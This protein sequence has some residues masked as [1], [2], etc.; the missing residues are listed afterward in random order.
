MKRV[1]ILVV[2][3]GLCMSCAT[4]KPLPESSINTTVLNVLGGPSKVE[5][6]ELSLVPDFVDE[7]LVLIRTTEITS[8]G[9]SSSSHQ[10]VDAP[11]GLY[12]GNG[13]YL[14]NSGNLSVLMDRVAGVKPGFIGTTQFST[15]LVSSMGGTDP[16]SVIQTVTYN[17][18]QITVSEPKGYGLFDKNYSVIIN[19]PKVEIFNVRITTNPDGI[20]KIAPKIGLPMSG[21]TWKKIDTG[22]EESYWQAAG[23]LIPYIKKD[24]YRLDNGV[25]TD[26][27]KTFR[28]ENNGMYLR[29][30]YTKGD[31]YAF[32]IY[33]AE[34]RVFVL[35]ENSGQGCVIDLAGNTLKW[36]EGRDPG[37]LHPSTSPLD[38]SLT[39]NPS[40]P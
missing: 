17:P 13:M 3:A 7:R 39:I 34:S 32:R 31:K 8:N 6:L 14:D 38:Y 22:Y 37:L 36:Q 28:V 5:P 23:G 40:Q 20:I 4:L 16:N 1:L 15:H 26:N 19:D 25:I 35:N 10:N 9:T 2:V 27:D 21:Q 24:Q 30:A 29:F 12:F 33:R 11:L 18:S